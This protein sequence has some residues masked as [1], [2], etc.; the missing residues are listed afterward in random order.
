VKGKE[1]LSNPE[2]ALRQLQEK[3][4]SLNLQFD[5]MMN[6]A[7]ERANRITME[8][9]VANL[10]M[11]QV[12]NASND[13]IWAID[14]SFKVIRVNKK[15]LS[16]LG[17]SDKE[18][19]GKKCHEL[20]PSICRENESCSKNK[21]FGGESIVE[22]DLTIQFKSGG[23]IP[24]KVTATPLS[25]LDGSTIGL[26]ETFTDITERKQ[27]EK[28]LQHA[29]REL[30][31]LSALDGLTGISNRRRFDEFLNTEWRRQ[32]REGNPVS[33]VL[34]DVDFFKKYNDTYGH[35]AGDACLKALAGAIQRS[36]HRVTDLGAR[37]G[38]EEFV[39]VMTATDIE[40]ACHIAEC[41]RQNVADLNMPHCQSAAAPHVT[42]SCGVASMI[43]TQ[44]T[45]PKMLIEKADQGLYRAK[46]QGRNRVVP[47]MDESS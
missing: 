24:F 6:E 47:N 46:Q 2:D 20:F 28:V 10:I 40:G 16:L 9:E 34:C 30:E 37:Y 42:I 17:K 41:M 25:D 13:G 45:N 23:I 1:S 26:V 35:Q 29:N 4:D 19:I 44:D 21:I 39:V 12:F 14:K 3:Y 7:M 18:V 11:K 36:V 27:A 31:R 38:G 5:E 8:A 22:R 15:L 32:I 33:L 43:P